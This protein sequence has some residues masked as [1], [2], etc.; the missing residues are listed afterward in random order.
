L[1]FKVEAPF[2]RQEFVR[3]RVL[4]YSAAGNAEGAASVE[5]TPVGFGRWDL[6]LYLL[7]L[8]GVG[9]LVVARDDPGEKTPELAH[10]DHNVRQAARG[11]RPVL[12]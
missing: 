6:L 10:H 7:P 5:I 1:Q 11:G 12:A 4:L 3:V 2:D 9:F 8:L